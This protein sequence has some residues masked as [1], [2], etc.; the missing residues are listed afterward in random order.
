MPISCAVLGSKDL[1]ICRMPSQVQEGSN[2][3]NLSWRCWTI[4]FSIEK[5]ADVEERGGAAGHGD[6]KSWKVMY[7]YYR[8]WPAMMRIIIKNQHKNSNSW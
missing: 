7:E 3:R 1:E 8:K 4:G 6:D 5:L 2:S